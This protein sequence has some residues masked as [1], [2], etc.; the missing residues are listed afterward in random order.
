MDEVGRGTSVQEGLVLAWAICHYLYHRNQ[1]RT[2]FAT[3]YHE[4]GN[5]STELA[6][7]RQYM[8]NATVNE[9]TLRL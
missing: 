2:L 7:C 8:T 4:L 1:C 3:H 5:R 9:V 6:H